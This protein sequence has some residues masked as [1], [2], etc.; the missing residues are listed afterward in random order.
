MK[1]IA[2]EIA[3]IIKENEIKIQ[4]LQKVQ[5]ICMTITSDDGI[6][7]DVELYSSYTRYIITGTRCQ[8]VICY[9]YNNKTFVRKKRNEKPELKKNYH[10][11]CRDIFNWIDDIKASKR[12]LEI[13]ELY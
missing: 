8:M 2:Y 6:D 11:N 1:N 3:D 5:S 7:V 13:L 9:D 12:E 10:T 4:Q